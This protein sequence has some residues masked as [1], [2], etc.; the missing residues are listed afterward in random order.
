MGLNGFFRA[1]VVIIS[2]GLCVG[3][4]VWLVSAQAGAEQATSVPQDHPPGMGRALTTGPATLPLRWR[5]SYAMQSDISATGS[6]GTFCGTA[7]IVL[8]TTSASV[9]AQVEWFH[10]GGSVG[11]TPVTIPAH[12]MKGWWSDSSPRLAPIKHSGAVSGTGFLIGYATVHAEDPRVVASAYL[13]CREAATG[14]TPVAAM[15]TIPTIPVGTSAE[16]FRAETSPAWTPPVVE[17]DLPK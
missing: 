10:T 14:D 5:L 1:T 7:V 9:D 11:Y 8:N 12:S 6:E 15:T 17:S 2:T 13:V 3:A 16:F 4:G